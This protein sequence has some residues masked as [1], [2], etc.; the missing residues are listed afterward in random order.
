MHVEDP[1]EWIH[2]L[3]LT[4]LGKASIRLARD[5]KPQHHKQVHYHSPR[6]SKKQPPNGWEP[7]CDSVASATVLSLTPWPDLDRPAKPGCS[8][9]WVSWFPNSGLGFWFAPSSANKQQA[10]RPFVRTEHPHVPKGPFGAIQP[11]KPSHA[12]GMA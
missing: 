9:T 8:L 12:K 10:F 7:D 6:V 1:V 3:Q 2:N 5:I 4:L 11:R